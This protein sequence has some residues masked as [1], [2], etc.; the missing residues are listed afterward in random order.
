M[1]KVMSEVLIALAFAIAG[2]LAA[3]VVETC[4]DQQLYCNRVQPKV[5]MAGKTEFSLGELCGLR[6]AETRSTIVCQLF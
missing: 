3:K 6:S 5:N 2:Y 4:G 1:H